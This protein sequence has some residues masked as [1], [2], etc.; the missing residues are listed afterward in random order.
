MLRLTTGLTKG[1]RLPVRLI[2]CGSDFFCSGFFL[3]ATATRCLGEGLAA[4]F[5]TF[6][7]D[8]PLA[9]FAAVLAFC[10]VTGCFELLAAVATL[11][12]G[13]EGLGA[14][15]TLLGLELGDCDAART[16]LESI[17][18]FCCTA[19]MVFLVFSMMSGF[20]AQ[21]TP[22]VIPSARIAFVSFIWCPCLP[23]QRRLGVA[24]RD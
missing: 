6:F 9:G 20:C 13:F 14:A 10:L 23:S 15:A 21:A 16:A 3:S 19:F 8:L 22:T 12:A 4:T 24:N 17:S 7:A 1:S 5:V 2:T 11:L 18:F